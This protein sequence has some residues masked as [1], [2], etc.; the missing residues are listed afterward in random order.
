MQTQTLL[1]LNQIGYLALLLLLGGYFVQLGLN[2]T[3]SWIF[4]LLWIVPLLFPIRGI[5]KGK[6]YTFAWAS[7][8]LCLY[9]LHSFTLLYVEDSIRAFSIVESVLL[10]GLLIGFSYYARLRGREL[11]LGLKKKKKD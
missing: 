4:S 5:I 8:I 6:P 7:F 9:L 11:G 10:M 1:K 2:G 3:Y